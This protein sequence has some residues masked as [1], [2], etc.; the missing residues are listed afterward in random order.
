MINASG[1]SYSGVIIGK[2]TT[3][4]YSDKSTPQIAISRHLCQT[5]DARDLLETSRPNALSQISRIEKSARLS[6][7]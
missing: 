2:I 4:I 3:T 1:D 6:S 5:F 7:D